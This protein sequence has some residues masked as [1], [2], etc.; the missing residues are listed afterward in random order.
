MTN[1][2]MVQRWSVVKFED[3]EVI[4]VERDK[5]NRVWNAMDLADG[6]EMVKVPADTMVEVVRVESKKFYKS[7]TK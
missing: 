2:W 1:S 7:I 4:L 5:E 3:K 6:H